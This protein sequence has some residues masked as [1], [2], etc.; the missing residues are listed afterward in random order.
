MITYLKVSKKRTEEWCSEMCNAEF[1]K[2]Q[3]N[4]NIEKLGADGG[5]E[6]DINMGDSGN[7]VSEID[8]ASDSEWIWA[9]SCDG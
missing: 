1:H 6:E 5:I 8:L 3:E 2:G 4:S 7:E 9:F